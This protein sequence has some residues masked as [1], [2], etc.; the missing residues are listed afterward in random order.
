MDIEQLPWVLQGSQSLSSNCPMLYQ[1]HKRLIFVP[2]NSL[3][4]SLESTAYQGLLWENQRHISTEESAKSAKQHLLQSCHVYFA[5]GHFSHGT[6]VGTVSSADPVWDSDAVEG[7]QD[8]G[9][10]NFVQ[11]TVASCTS[12]E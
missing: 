7:T 10:R 12:L 11:A 1:L 3:S 6:P 2:A 9:L 5:A 4:L 8:M